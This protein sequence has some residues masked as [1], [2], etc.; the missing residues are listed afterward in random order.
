MSKTLYVPIMLD[1]LLVGDEDRG[2]ADVDYD[3]SL[4]DEETLFGDMISNRGFGEKRQLSGAHLQW[5]MPDA[6]LH[7]EKK[8]DGS[9]SFPTLPNRFLIQRMKVD[10]ADVSW[11]AWMLRSDFVTNDSHKTSEGMRKTVIPALEYC[12][13][14]GCYQPA[15]DDGKMYAFVGSVRP[16]GEEETEKEKWKLPMTAIGLGDPLATAYYPL[17]KTVF[18]FYDSLDEGEGVYTYLVS[19]YYEDAMQDLLHVNAAEKMKEFGWEMDSEEEVERCLIYGMSHG[20]VWRGRTHS[21]AKIPEEEVRIDIGNTSME[22][23]ASLLASPFPE[24]EGMERL[25]HGLPYGLLAVADN[26]GRTDTLIEMEEQL[27]ATQFNQINGG[28]KWVLRMQQ[29]KGQTSGQWKLDEDQYQKMAALNDFN[30]RKNRCREDLESA[31]QELYMFWYQYVQFKVADPQYEKLPEMKARVTELAGQIQKQK[32]EYVNLEQA[33]SERKKELESSLKKKKLYLEETPQGYYYEPVPPVLMLSGEGVGRSFRQGHQGSGEEGLSVTANPVSELNILSG[34]KSYM[35]LASEVQ[36][37]LSIPDTFP[38]SSAKLLGECLL[39]GEEMI[40][41]LIGVVSRKY[42]GKPSEEEM[43]AAQEKT[44]CSP[45]AERAWVQPW[46]PLFLLWEVS[47][48]HAAKIQGKD[49]TFS[50]FHL[51]ELDWEMDG[52][53]QEGKQTFQG[54]SLLTPHGVTQMSRGCRQVMKKWDRS[55]GALEGR[56]AELEMASVLSQQM[57]G[58]HEAF[59][60]RSDMPMLPILS[61]DEETMPLAKKVTECLNGYYHMPI[62]GGEDSP[63]LPIRGGALHL[64]RLRLIDSFGQYKEVGIFSHNVH[65]SESLRSGDDKE[66]LLRPRFLQPV[67]IEFEW[68]SAEHE[69]SASFDAGSTP[70]TGFLVPM[71]LDHCIYVYDNQGRL[72]GS[73]MEGEEQPYWHQGMGNCKT[74]EGITNPFLRKFVTGLLAGKPEDMGALMRYLRKFLTETAVD[75]HME[76]MSQCFG[77]ILALCRAKVSLSGYGR[78]RKQLI[79][80]TYTTREYEKETVMVRLGDERRISNGLAGYVEETGQLYDSF[81]ILESGEGE[82]QGYLS[83]SHDLP[84]SLAQGE[85]RLL[86][87]MLPEGEISIRGGFVPAMKASL[88]KEMYEE[89]QAKI[90]R[91]LK[92]KPHLAAEGKVTLPQNQLMGEEWQFCYRDEE[93][94]KQQE[95][96][97]RGVDFREEEKWLVEGFLLQKEEKGEGNNG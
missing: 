57:S 26:D 73:I 62:L 63:F 95:T 12:P 7:G 79:D 72:S 44:A 40:P 56:L 55:F 42:Q 29:D 19:G 6:L 71:F 22:T 47:I 30:D 88:Q 78:T 75:E 51:E 52:K 93:G 13:Q 14:S 11:K 17:S 23:M 89:R 35:L 33:V 41:F 84:L 50:S 32:E 68:M 34:K 70:L 69:D 61:P 54:L 20:V 5:T 58:F 8:E 3:Y 94:E 96:E 39:C 80:D 25:F 60:A 43:R 18:G 27:H 66:V 76:I 77:R 49:T 21:Y 15:G 28:T 10:G 81:H 97:S 31:S 1:V 67:R 4:L 82:K 83:S 53:F 91:M 24:K 2:Y 16:F 90:Q 86:F 85:K 65:I 64:E 74:A 92:L 36:K 87:L 37:E 59:S 46:N 48:S 9:V 38:D 45:L